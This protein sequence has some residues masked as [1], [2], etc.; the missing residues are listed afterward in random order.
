MAQV[1]S[2]RVVAFDVGLAPLMDAERIHRKKMDGNE[3]ASEP[4]TRGIRSGDWLMKA[5]EKEEVRFAARFVR[6]LC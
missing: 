5:G 2:E 4:R 6:A 3:E 1:R